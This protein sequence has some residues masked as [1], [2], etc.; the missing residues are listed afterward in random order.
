MKSQ[1]TTPDLRP[2]GLALSGAGALSAY[3]L[4]LNGAAGA[5]NL[6]VICGMTGSQ[7]GHCA[8]C[9]ANALAIATGLAL[10][11]LGAPRRRAVAR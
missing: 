5:L 4:W 7:L 11:A 3:A 10:M 1:Q 6:G 2:A 8:V 9:Y